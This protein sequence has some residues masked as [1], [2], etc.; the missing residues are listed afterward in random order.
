VGLL[1][2]LP[3]P[4]DESDECELLDLGSCRAP[5]TC[6]KLLVISLPFVRTGRD[7]LFTLEWGWRDSPV[8]LGVE[9]QM[10]RLSA[11]G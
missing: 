5:V 6:Q 7:A 1:S 11:L 3:V 10:L 4:E 8:Q 2:P 9:P